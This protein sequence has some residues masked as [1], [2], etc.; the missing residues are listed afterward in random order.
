MIDGGERDLVIV[1]LMFFFFLE[2][3]EVLKIEITK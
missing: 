1:W 3:L 2:A